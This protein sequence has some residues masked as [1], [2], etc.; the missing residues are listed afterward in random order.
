MND[1]DNV[2]PVYQEFDGW[3]CEL[4]GI[5]S[6]NN[7]YLNKVGVYNPRLEKIISIMEIFPALVIH[8]EIREVR[9]VTF[10]NL[11]RIRGR[12]DKKKQSQRI[13]IKQIRIKQV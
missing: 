11:L 5:K 12:R 9:F 2:V 1:L 13:A 4:D 8:I 10:L 6:F 7:L 3:E